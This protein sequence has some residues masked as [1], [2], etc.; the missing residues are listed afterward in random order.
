MLPS[1]VGKIEVLTILD[2][3]KNNLTSL[4]H[5]IMQ[6]KALIGLYL[7]NNKLASLPSE[8]GQLK[9]L[10]ELYLFSNKLTTL[11]PKIGQLKALKVLYLFNNQ[12][13]TL[14]PEIGQLKTLTSLDLADNQLTSLTP[15]ISQ[16]KALKE[17]YLHDNPGLGIPDSVLGAN[18]KTVHSSESNKRQPLANPVDI[19]NFYFSQKQAA[20]EGTLKHVNE[21]KLM[22]VGRGGAGKT[23]LRRFFLNQP[24]KSNEAE[25]PGIALDSFTLKCHGQHIV[26]R[27]WDFAG[28][29]ITHALHQ[30]FLTEGCIYILVLDPRSNTEMTD[31][32]YWLNLLKRYAGH[33]PVV[34][35]MNRQDER[36]GGY[37]VDRH[38]IKERFPHIQSFIPT[39]CETRSGCDDLRVA[40]LKAIETLNPNEPPRLEVPETWLKVKQ[41]C[42]ERG[43]AEANGSEQ[44][45]E[46]RTH[47]SL[48]QF[49]QICQA[50]RVID[51]EKQ[52]SLARLLHRLGAVLHFVD[53][54]RLRDTSVL[55]PHWVTDGVY[56][57]LRFKDR[58]KSDGI[59]SRDDLTKAL[60]DEDEKSARFLLSLMERFEMCY[61]LDEGDD[62]KFASQW[63]IPG[64]L[65]Q[66][67]PAD[68]GPEWQKPGSVRLRYV[69]DP[70]PEGVIPRFI[71]MTHPLSNRKLCWRN[72]VVLEDAQAAV[73]VR[74]GEK[75][76]IVEIIAFGPDAERL[77]LLQ[78]VQGNME[79]INADVPEPRPF[80]EQEID[81]LPG[82]YKRVTEL[83]GAEI[84]K[85][86]VVVESN[87]DRKLVKI[88]PT[89]QLNR[90]SEPE[91]RDPDRVPL[92][93]FLSYSQAD[94]RAKDI[95]VTN[96]N[97]MKSKKLITPWH[98]GLIEPGIQWSDELNENLETMDIFVGLLT[99]H[100][101]ASNFI[102]TV[103][104]KAAREKLQKVGKEFLF[105][106]ILVDDISLDGLE[107]AEYQILKP[108]GKPV[109]K[110]KSRKDGFNEAQ[111]EL[112]KLIKSRQET[113][114]A[115]RQERAPSVAPMKPEN[116]ADGV[117]FLD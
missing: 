34:V 90:I 53:D 43:H 67:Q 24:H 30:F 98:D 29:E 91:S 47:L 116:K 74:R 77:R 11:P 66:Y 19:L 89:T 79:R 64:A 113:K 26:V 115:E 56:R 15:E 25:T 78:I 4:P 52:K 48:E 35:A 28:Q 10:T 9:A 65:H 93:A 99:N 36:S 13:T 81:G 75:P 31:A 8:I 7:N 22:L 80:L 107:L 103:E 88:E 112:E 87:R 51:P 45:V 110:H 73:L 38:L 63:L 72:G 39:N 27:L 105:V 100:F 3:S 106:L 55:D 85:T 101:V 86:P 71:V 46:K 97:V 61:P 12:L 70:L 32:F 50:H 57:L 96:L 5:E 62:G 104:L 41:E 117:T 109:C 6:F 18:Y 23:S 68:I 42:F 58:P 95:F 59:L 2:L 69:Y 37:D 40:L 20:F 49:Q 1:E 76:N 14:P 54:I 84:E 111:K 83:E 102:Q 92:N 21:I 33:S 114:K 60:P 94:K 17:L 16:L 82:T 108:G 44:P